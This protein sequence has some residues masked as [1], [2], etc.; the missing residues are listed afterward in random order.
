MFKHEHFT[1]WFVFG[2]SATFGSSAFAQD[3][4]APAPSAAASASVTASANNGASSEASATAAAPAAPASKEPA[5]EPYEAGFPPENGLFELGVFG[6]II[7]PSSDHNLRYEA[8]PQR[9]YGVGGEFG[10]RLGYYPLSFLGVE[11]EAMT[12]ASKIK[13]TETSAAIYAGRLQAV[14]QAPLPYVTPFLL[15][16]VGR[17]GAISRSQANDSDPAWHFGI[18][19]KVPITHSFGLRVDLRDTLTKNTQ[20]DGQAHTFEIQLGLAATLGRTRRE[21]PPPPPDSDHDGFLDRDDQCPADPGVAPNGCPADT[22]TDGVLDRDDFCPRE[23]GPAPKGCPIVNLDPD[24]DGVLLPC[25]QCPTEAGT[26]PLGCPIRDTD[27]DGILD[28]KDKCPKEPETKNGFEDQDG[29]PDTVPEAVKKFTGVVQGIF[30]EKNK[31]TIRADSSPVLGKAAKVFAQFPVHVEI[32]G[33]TSSEGDEA[34]NQQLSLDRAQAV[35]DW[36]IKAGTPA[37]RISIRGAGPSEPIADNKTNAGRERNRRIE[38]KLL[39]N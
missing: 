37:D 26:K 36:L 12:A 3:A 28:D 5:Y 30:F 7:F 11:A 9:P 33:H 20:Q 31:A 19:A 16:G 15:V 38:F 4:A 6:G 14:L 2:L 18:G 39:L 34:F 24:Q 1:S 25:D 10:A 13:D 8:Y 17:L 35:K 23:A 32:S 29:C 21:P 27:G 22:D